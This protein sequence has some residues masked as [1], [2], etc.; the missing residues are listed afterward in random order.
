MIQKLLCVYVHEDPETCLL[1]SRYSISD[2][3]VGATQ[4]SRSPQLSIYFQIITGVRGLSYILWWLES[5]GI[6]S[7]RREKSGTFPKVLSQGLNAGESGNQGSDQFHLRLGNSELPRQQPHCSK[8]SRVRCEGRS[9]EVRGMLGGSFLDMV[10]R[11]Q[12]WP[13]HTSW[14][15]E[16]RSREVTEGG[17]WGILCT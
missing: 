4:C 15:G 11:C 16:R 2:E 9:P 17:V 6:N 5:G 12:R 7:Q 10:N 13:W 1:H 14:T 8:S 3:G